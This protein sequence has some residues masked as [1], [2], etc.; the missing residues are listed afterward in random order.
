L[1]FDVFEKLIREP[2]IHF[3]ALGGVLSIVGRPWATTEQS[4][5]GQ[6]CRDFKPDREPGGRFHAHMD[7]PTTLLA[8]TIIAA[9]LGLAHGQLNGAGMGQPE[10][11]AVA[12]FGLVFMVFVTVAFSAA[13]VVRL[14]R[15]W[16]RIAVRVVGSWI[17]AMGLLMRGWNLHVKL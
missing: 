17:V 13:F 7:A 2:I 10:V 6:N 11:G 16:T 12:L 8:T 1:E 14:H 9:L 5:I 3:I 4:G 15:P